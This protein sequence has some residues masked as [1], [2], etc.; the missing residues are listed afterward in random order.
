[1]TGCNQ[2]HAL[3]PQHFS[4]GQP[5]RRSFKPGLAQ[6]PGA[7]REDRCRPTRAHTSGPA[8][9]TETGSRHKLLF[10]EARALLSRHRALL[11]SSTLMPFP[12]G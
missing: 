10:L 4:P 5:R 6:T 11:F 12:C 7:V 1:M 2:C 9:P 3:E 8:D